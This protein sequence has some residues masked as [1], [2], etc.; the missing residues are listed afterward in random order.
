MINFALDNHIYKVCRFL[1]GHVSLQ[2]GYVDKS[3]ACEPGVLLKEYTAIRVA[4]HSPVN[5]A[6][7]SGASFLFK[8]QH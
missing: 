7:L 8:K 2:H 5:T 6:G 4:S 1:C 3:N